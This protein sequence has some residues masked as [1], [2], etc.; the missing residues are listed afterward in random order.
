MEPSPVHKIT[1]TFTARIPTLQR[2]EIDRLRRLT[3]KSRA[4]ESKLGEKGLALAHFG[5]VLRAGGGKSIDDYYEHLA[6][7]QMGDSPTSSI[8]DRAANRTSFFAGTDQLD[9]L[10]AKVLPALRQRPEVRLWCAAT[11][12]G[13]ECY[14]IAFTLLEATGI[15]T[16]RKIHLVAT[17]MSARALQIAKRGVYPAD[18]FAGLPQPVRR[19]CL[20]RGREAAQGYYKVRPE[21]QRCLE[22][23]RLNVSE[24]IWHPGGFPV[25][26]CRD[27][28]IRFGQSERRDVVNR[29][30]QWLEP[31]G[32]LFVDQSERLSSEDAA[33]EYTQPGIYR[34]PAERAGQLRRGGE[35][36]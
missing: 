32:Y 35:R 2:K 16:A 25:I 15:A 9:F 10:R 18:H 19:R 17:D 30:M 34:K 23:R 12:T 29:L 14:S 27:A 28:L 4:S 3:A 7:D 1:F 8:D 36:R 31:H 22:F 33:L 6:L 5:R 21:V 11:G 26:F 20:L 13:E 24:K